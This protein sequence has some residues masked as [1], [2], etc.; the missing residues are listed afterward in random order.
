MNKVLFNTGGQPV[1]LDDLETIQKLA[2]ESL[3]GILKLLV[4]SAI[5]DYIGYWTSDN[6]FNNLVPMGSVSTES[7]GFF[8]TPFCVISR[9][10]VTQKLVLKFIDGGY[11]CINNEILEYEKTEVD[12]DY[13]SPFYVIVKKDNLDNRTLDNG[14]QVPCTEHKYAVISKDA[15]ETDCYSSA[16]LCSLTDAIYNIVSAKRSVAENK[17]KKLSVGF[18]NGYAGTVEYRE[19]SDCYRYRINISSQNGT[20]MTGSFSLFDTYESGWPGG[21][22]KCVSCLF[23]AGGDDETYPSYISFGQDGD[24]RIH[25]L[26]SNPIEWR[27]SNCPVK[28]VFDVSK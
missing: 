5:P 22:R 20:E 17:W 4:R 16:E 15:A 12:I 1:Y 14:E 13:Y 7:K 9:N 21:Y 8:I 28:I 26:A 18:M 23:G 19:L 24:A 3:P 2:S 10:D 27:P 6:I 25:C 11:V